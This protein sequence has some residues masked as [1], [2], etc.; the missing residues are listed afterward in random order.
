M[1]FSD[2]LDNFIKQRDQQSQSGVKTTF[3]RQSVIQEPTNQSVAREAIAKAQEEAA[4]QATIESKA[5][6]VRINGRC[7][8][9]TEAQVVNQLKEEAKPANPSR[10]DYIHQLRKEL[11]LRKRTKE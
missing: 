5:P 7:V 11:K 2:Y 1:S 3:R 8:T 4:E 10:I 6:H 9:E